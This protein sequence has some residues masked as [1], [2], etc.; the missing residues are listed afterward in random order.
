M[1]M[2][3][4]SQ[5]SLTRSEHKI[6]TSNFLIPREPVSPMFCFFQITLTQEVCDPM[7][8]WQLKEWGR[9]EDINWPAQKQNSQ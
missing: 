3:G 5:A 9:E 6:P 7:E 1:L 4:I 2:V 8:Q